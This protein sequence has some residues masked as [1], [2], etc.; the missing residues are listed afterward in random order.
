MHD[1]EDHCCPAAAAEAGAEGADFVA[2]HRLDDRRRAR[3][4]PSIVS[5]LDAGVKI[6]LEVLIF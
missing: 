2:Q 6:A 1:E 4:P 3:W 5:T